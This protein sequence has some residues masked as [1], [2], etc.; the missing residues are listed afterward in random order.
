MTRPGA[1]LD[2]PLLLRGEPREAVVPDAAMPFD[3]IVSDVACIPTA[4]DDGLGA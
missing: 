1:R 2:V 4:T 3:L